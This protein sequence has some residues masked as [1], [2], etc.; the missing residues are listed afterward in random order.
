LSAPEKTDEKP[1]RSTSAELDFVYCIAEKKPAESGF[2]FGSFFRLFFASTVGPMS[3][4]KEHPLGVVEAL[5]SVRDQCPH[6]AVRQHASRALQAVQAGGP[7]ELRRQAFLVF[8]TIAGWRGPRAQAVKRALR[9]FLDETGHSASDA[10][11]AA[12]SDAAP[13]EREWSRSE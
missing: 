2:C 10:A 13:K 5:V 12:P 8:S 4:G 7:A 3:H 6:A 1:L 11:P 9:G